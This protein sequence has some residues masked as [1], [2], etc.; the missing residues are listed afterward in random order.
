MADAVLVEIAGPV[1]LVTMNRP[2][3]RNALGELADIDL[4]VERLTQ[5]SLNRDVRVMILTGAGKAFAAGGNVKDMRDKVGMFGGGV[6]QIRENYKRTVQR[7]ARTL[8]DVTVPTIAAVNGPAVG[9]GCDLACLCDIRIA[10]ESAKFSVPFL[11]LGLV[12]GDGGSWLLPRVVGRSRA[13]ELFFT[14][15]MLDAKTAVEWGLASRVVAD[16]QLMAEARKLAE[17][18]ATMPPD[19]LR[20]TKRLLRQ[21]DEATFDQVQDASAAMQAIAHTTEDHREAIDAFFEKR[22]GRYVGR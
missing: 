9:Q 20:M 4:F 13:A 16:D 12:P 7:L 17:K 21:A 1:A 14:G 3:A 10:G 19:V 5:V 8:Y 15:D 22:D 11:K 2:E 6:G 18:I